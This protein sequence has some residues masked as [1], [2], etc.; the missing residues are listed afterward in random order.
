MK[1]MNR[2]RLNKQ[3]AGAPEGAAPGC[4]RG[5]DGD[6][7]R[8]FAAL[9]ALDTFEAGQPGALRSSMELGSPEKKS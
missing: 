2:H 7:L 6:V 5:G 9:A 1:K 8:A 3:I 4:L